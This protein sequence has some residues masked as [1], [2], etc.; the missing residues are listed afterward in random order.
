MDFKKEIAG[1]ISQE[2][3]LKR[4][5]IESLIEIPPDQAF[6]DYA[7][8]CFSLAKQLRK[9][10]LLIAEE[11]SKKLSTNEFEK[12]EAKAGYLNFFVRRDILAR[13]VLAAVFKE[14]AKYGTSQ[15]GKGK[16]I[17]IDMSSPNI[18]KRFGIGHLRSTII[19]NSLR[20]IF[21]AQGYKVIR[22]N[23][24]GDWGTQF[25]NLITAFKRWGKEKELEKKP[26]HYL[27]SL[28]VKFHKEA[29]QDTTLEDEGRLWFKRLEQRDKEALALWKKFRE[30]SIE[31]FNKIYKTLG[32]EF[33]SYAGESFYNDML[34][35]AIQEVKQRGLAS[36][37]EGALVIDLEKFGMPPALLKKADGATLYLTRDLAA[38]M[39][40]HKS[41]KFSKL[42][43][44]VGS[45]QKMHF[46]QLFKV[47]ELMGF[48]WAKDCVHVDHGLY[49]DTDGK[50]LSTRKGK[51]FFMEDIIQETSELALKIIKE[52]NPE[53]KNK[54]K[55]AKQVAIAAILFGDLSNDR[56]NNI[57]FDLD[58]FLSFEGETGP[59]IQY[60]HARIC[61]ILRKYKKGTEL[62]VDFSLLSDEKEKGIIKHLQEYP[63]VIQKAG[64]DYKP[65]YIARYLLELAQA[66]ND[67]Y[68][69]NPVLQAEDELKKARI[70]LIDCVRD[71]LKS[72]LA[73]LGIEA[74]EEM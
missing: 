9:N 53:L 24:L 43:Y 33:E 31:E 72:G 42:I 25:G 11:L 51:T 71:V 44:E 60:T 32:I 74:P 20:H 29:E 21:T 8:P 37:S 61:S 70:L 23:H 47:L 10:P 58:R 16:T 59:Y 73:L 65:S 28:Y 2:L 14:K 4:E 50:K 55:I 36:M 49:L 12:V 40:R 35:D 48:S 41:Y 3:K 7:F 19:G 17:V 66:V 15:A 30:L 38:A 26:I 69:T 18:A 64:D 63:A 56:M 62:K 6:G 39:Y 45:E 13:E 68:H 57:I 34:D 27:L 52:K 67:F 1:L 54:E 22:V 5:E 46:R